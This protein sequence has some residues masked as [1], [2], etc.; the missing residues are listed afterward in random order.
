MGAELLAEITPGV[1]LRRAVRPAVTPEEQRDV[2]QRHTNLHTGR[3]SPVS[4]AQY[5]GSMS[6]V[7]TILRGALLALLAMTVAWGAVEVFARQFT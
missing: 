6:V 2:P 5:D 1:V 4:R 3:Q 7:R